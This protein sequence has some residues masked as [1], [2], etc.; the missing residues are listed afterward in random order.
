MTTKMTQPLETDGL[1]KTAL[2]STFKNKAVKVTVGLGDYLRAHICGVPRAL[3]SRAQIA[4]V[5][6]TG[7]H[8]GPDRAKRG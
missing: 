3:A 8:H 7:I 6:E 4:W 2:L 1:T 5:Q